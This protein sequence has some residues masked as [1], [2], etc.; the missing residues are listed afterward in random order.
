MRIR[1]ITA[2]VVVIGLGGVAA[3]GY[4]DDRATRP[5]TEVL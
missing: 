3:L 1:T 2:V 5:A 4:V